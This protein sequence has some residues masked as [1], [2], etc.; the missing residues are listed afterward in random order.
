MQTFSILYHRYLFDSLQCTLF[1]SV[2]F[3]TFKLEFKIR[4]SYPIDCTM[5]IHELLQI[6]SNKVVNTK[7]GSNQIIL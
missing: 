5:K 4:F 6:G 1:T 3:D 2:L 7:I